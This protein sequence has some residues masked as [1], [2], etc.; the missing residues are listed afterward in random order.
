M[1]RRGN[2]IIAILLPYVLLT[3][4]PLGI[5]V[6]RDQITS[7]EKVK[8]VVQIA[9]IVGA[10]RIYVQVVG[11]ADAY[12][13]SDILPRSEA[14]SSMPESFDPLREIVN[15]AK[16]AGLKVSA[17]MNVFYV[18]PFN[19]RPKSSKHIINA[20]P[21]WVTYDINGRSM[22]EYKFSPEVDTPG[23]FLDPALP[24]VKEFVS[25]IAEE[26]A[27]KYDVDEIHLDYIRYPYKTF[28]YHPQA[29]KL[30]REWL[31]KELAEKRLQNIAEGFD[32]FRRHQVS[33]T[34][35]L[36]YEKVHRYGKNLSAAVFAYYEPDA[37]TQRLQEW[38]EWV[39]GGYLDYACMMAYE[40][41]K[42]IVNSH[43]KYAV[44]KLGSAEKIRVGLGA[45]K[46][47]SYP[48]KLFEIAQS[49]ALYKPDEIIIFSFENLFQ[50]TI[51]Q[52]VMNIAYLIQKGGN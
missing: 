13:D 26:I 27:R 6:V 24:E 11:R 38:I 3:A 29:Q 2:F 9:K 21:E 19:S 25:S 18:W 15:L 34:V 23:I 7:P 35:K 36:I 5:W 40:D 28:G 8:Q 12:Y 4:Y 33:E 20:H 49:V 42:E 17:W 14:L 48:N 10:N 32:I 16:P 43:V 50:E 31:K 41:N 30:Y 1:L 44:N 52:T 39:K 37:L 46:L 47:T 22:L 45:Y 51:K